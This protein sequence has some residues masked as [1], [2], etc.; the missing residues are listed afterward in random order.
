MAQVS[1]RIN[2]YAYILGCADGEE[3]HLTS[4][5]ADLDRRIEEI[6]ASTGPSGEA[7]L[8]LMA[9]LVLADELHDLRGEI[10]PEAAPRPAPMKPDTKANKR[11]SRLARRAE[12]LAD[13]AETPSHDTVGSEHALPAYWTAPTQGEPEPEPDGEAADT[14][15]AR[16]EHADV[17]DGKT[18][19]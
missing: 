17:H 4:L 12:T 13:Q 10:D 9:A 1:L 19:A 16:A 18:Q 15:A 8:L 7:R 2:G 3:A 11:L 14:R 5:A 6:K